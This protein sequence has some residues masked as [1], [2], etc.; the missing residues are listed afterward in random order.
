MLAPMEPKAEG[1]DDAVA[2][3]KQSDGGWSAPRSAI[4][5]PVLPAIGVGVVVLLVV[6]GMALALG[7]NVASAV[8]TAVIPALA[9]GATAYVVIVRGRTSRWLATGDTDPPT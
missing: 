1:W 9:F 8:Q 7:G 2:R 4:G 5:R 3:A 6:F